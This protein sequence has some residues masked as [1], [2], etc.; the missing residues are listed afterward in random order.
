MHQ[1][2]PGNTY[3]ISTFSTTKGIFRV[4]SALRKKFRS[5]DNHLSVSVSTYRP[6]TRASPGKQGMGGITFHEGTK[7]RCPKFCQHLGWRAEAAVQ[8]R[9]GCSEDY[10]RI[11]HSKQYPSCS[12]SPQE[13]EEI[14]T[15]LVPS[16][17][18]RLLSAA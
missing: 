13:E 12:S 2:N 17:S 9:W 7:P 11:I 4:P 1:P 18:Y 16:I 6:V 5:E 10:F 14:Q 15:G 8:K 3:T